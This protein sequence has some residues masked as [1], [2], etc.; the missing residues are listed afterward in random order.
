MV[1]SVKVTSY[2]GE[3]IVLDLMNPWKNGL[4]ITDIEGIGVVKA[5]INYTENASGDGGRYNSSRIGTRNIVFTIRPLSIGFQTVED[6][7]QLLY[8][9]FHI[10]Q[11]VTLDFTTERRHARITGYVEDNDPNIFSDEESVQISIIC[12]DP[13]FYDLK[14]GGETEVSFSGTE[15]LFEFPFENNSTSSDLIEFGEITFRREQLI[16]YNGSAE[17]GFVIRIHASGEAKMITIYNIDTRESMRIDTDRFAQ[18][19]G[20]EIQNGD[21]IVISTI[22]GQK[23][24]IL[25]RDGKEW[26]I[27]NSLDKDSSWLKLKSGAN[28]LAYICDEGAEY[29]DFTLTYK[30]AFEGL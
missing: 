14:D 18:I 6:S 30:T 21:E 17:V 26:N 10:K 23:S 27:L 7:R 4:A 5:T 12:A 29:L 3:E 8:R 15:A 28:R 19:A 11:L 1:Y 25:I 24:V 9:Y 13:Y 20:S 2:L 16:Q 22:T